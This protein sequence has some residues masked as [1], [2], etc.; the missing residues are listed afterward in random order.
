MVSSLPVGGPL[1]C[2]SVSTCPRPRVRSG[3]ADQATS[4]TTQ[5][6]TLYVQRKARDEK[7]D[8]PHAALADP[9]PLPPL[10]TP[11]APRGPRR[12]FRVLR[13][14]VASGSERPAYLC[15]EL[16]GLLRCRDLPARGP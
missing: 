15:L 1:V 9:P 4:D 13:S 7:S 11:H 6:S 8:D 12:G 16:P 3:G 10:A 14:L 2:S 5:S